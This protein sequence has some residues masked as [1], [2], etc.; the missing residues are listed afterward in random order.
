M[1]GFGNASFRISGFG[2]RWILYYIAWK[3]LEK[4]GFLD[5]GHLYHIWII[6]LNFHTSLEIELHSNNLQ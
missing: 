6:I 2:E 3:V 4:S 5:A 1:P